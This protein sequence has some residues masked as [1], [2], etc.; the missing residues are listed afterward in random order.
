MGV[1]PDVARAFSA[2]MPLARAPPN[3]WRG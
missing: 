1:E 2:E 3:R